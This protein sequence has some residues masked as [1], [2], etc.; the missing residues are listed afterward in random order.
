MFQCGITAIHQFIAIEED[1][2]E[3][4]FGTIHT[5]SVIC[6]V[7]VFSILTHSKMIQCGISTIHVNEFIAI[8]EDSRNIE[9]TFGTI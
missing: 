4:R 9:D 3:D 6:Y 5:T 1:R 7:I 8:E 2:N